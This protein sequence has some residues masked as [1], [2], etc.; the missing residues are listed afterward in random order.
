[1]GLGAGLDGQRSSLIKGIFGHIRAWKP[2]LVFLENVPEVLR[3]GSAKYVADNFSE[4]GYIFAWGTI[5]ADDVGFRH[6]RLRWFC[7]GVLPAYFDLLKQCLDISE[8]ASLERQ[9]VEPVRMVAER[10]G[11]RLGALGNSVVPQAAKKAFE[12]LG[13]TILNA[14]D[15]PKMPYYISNLYRFQWAYFSGETK[16]LIERPSFE[17]TR[18]RHEDFEELVIVPGSYESPAPPSAQM[19]SGLLT[20]PKGRRAWSTPR[21]GNPWPCNYLTKR[22][23][24]DLGTQMRFE[25][26]TPENLRG[27][28]PAPRFLE[29]LMGYPMD[30]T[31]IVEDEEEE[32]DAKRIKV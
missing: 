16:V 27:L 18:F 13:R 7:L 14:P 10:H 12:L 20:S 23:E 30:Y 3:N 2:K 29:W 4:T 22:S 9:T 1:M 11:A 32:P 6:G 24:M 25:K 21:H 19:T 15:E 28:Y 26:N 8:S 5:G 31:E 17:S